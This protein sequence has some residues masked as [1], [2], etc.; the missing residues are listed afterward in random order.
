MYENDIFSFCKPSNEF[1]HAFCLS[2][3]HLNQSGL[4]KLIQI[5]LKSTGVLLGLSPVWNCYPKGSLTTG[6][7]KS[8]IN[9]YDE[10]EVEFSK[11]KCL[12]TI[13]S[14]DTIPIA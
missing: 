11:N 2:K 7:T 9:G 13:R 10:I 6:A 1:I 14:T 8:S 5:T 3:I 12:G 4:L